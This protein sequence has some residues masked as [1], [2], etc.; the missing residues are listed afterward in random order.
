MRDWISIGFAAKKAK[1][2]F[3]LQGQCL[4]VWKREIQTLMG[5]FFLYCRLAQAVDYA[6]L[7]KPGFLPA[8]VVTWCGVP[9]TLNSCHKTSLLFPKFVNL[10]GKKINFGCC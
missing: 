3:C 2:G 1:L 6:R 7:L 9:E 8:A 10:Q 4:A 5:H